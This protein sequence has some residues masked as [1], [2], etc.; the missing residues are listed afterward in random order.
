MSDDERPTWLRDLD[1]ND[2]GEG[3]PPDSEFDAW[4]DRVAPSIHAPPSTPR[5]EMWDAIAARAAVGRATPPTAI[6]VWRSRWTWPT[7]IAAALL[8]GIG[9]DRVAIGRDAATLQTA[10]SADTA[11]T[12]AGKLYR[13]VAVGTL[14]QAEALLTAYRADTAMHRD[15]AASQQLALWGR[16]VL[17]STR[18]LLDSPAGDDP[19]FRRL[20]DDLE[21]VLV[22]I[23]RSTGTELDASERALIEHALKERNLLP[24][25][26]T[27]VPAGGAAAE[28][29]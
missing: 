12:D 14:G 28:T 16:Q 11:A 27:V 2:E 4:I 29:D 25:I 7:A 21:L 23:I 10:H 6:S 24:R 13:L 9:I 22:Q 3:L 26:R 20:L 1:S 18:L 8:V 19:Q 17:S 15:P 5:A